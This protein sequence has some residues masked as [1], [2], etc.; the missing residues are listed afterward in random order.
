MQLV[1]DRAEDDP[2]TSKVLSLDRGRTWSPDLVSV[3]ADGLLLALAIAAA[4]GVH[5]VLT[6]GWRPDLAKTGTLSLLIFATI[7]ILRMWRPDRGSLSPCI[8]V[9][10]GGS[11]AAAIFGVAAVVRVFAEASPVPGTFYL[12]TAVTASTAI[13]CSR[14]LA[15]RLRR[16]SQ[17][18]ARPYERRILIL[19]DRTCRE[20]LDRVPSVASAARIASV[21][22][23]P[24]DP[25]DRL[26]FLRQLSREIE[27]SQQ[28]EI[29]LAVSWTDWTDIAAAMEE[30]KALPLPVRLLPD[31]AALRILGY[32]RQNRGGVPT[33][34][35]RPPSM[36]A[37]GRAAKRILD[38]AGAFAGLVLLAPLLVSVAAA[39]RL[40]TPGPVF[41]RQTRGGRYGRPFRIWKFRTMRVVEDGPEIAQATRGDTRVTAVGRWLRSTSIDELPQ[42][43]NVLHGAMSLIGPRPHALAH[44]A[45]YAKVIQEYP[46]RYH[47]KPGLTGWAQVNGSRG[48]TAQVSDMISRVDLDVWYANH[49]SFWLD[50]KI[51][52]QTVFSVRVYRSA[53]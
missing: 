52:I 9:A 51:L 24:G 29:W 18:W 3:L 28:D 8:V 45:Q 16:F 43:L 38:I 6:P 21:R 22:D 46:R 37:I 50:V 26:P 2:L 13:L 12:L 30:L 39:I 17:I 32:R 20:V 15:P 48:E 27:P 41:F 10:V 53:Y 11:C 40:E 1:H 47:V 5:I 42:L 4:I 25:V 36:P 14:A 34:E 31:P 33:F 49:W 7:L 23:L 44:D 35:L 19:T